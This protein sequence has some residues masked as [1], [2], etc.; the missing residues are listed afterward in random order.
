VPPFDALFD[1]LME[2]DLRHNFVYGAPV[3]FRLATGHPEQITAII[4]QN[5]NAYEEGL[6]EEGPDLSNRTAEAKLRLEA[7]PYRRARRTALA[8]EANG[9]HGIPHFCGLT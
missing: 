9:A 2:G 5:G 4:S 8:P 3:G 1:A 6:S 7:I